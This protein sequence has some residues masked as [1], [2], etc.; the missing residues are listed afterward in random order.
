MK[1]SALIAALNEGPRIGGVVTGIR[2]HVADVLVV[3]DGSTDDTS[4][5]AQA[6]GASVIRHDVNR[7]KGQAIRT[8]LARVARR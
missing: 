5:A 4:A 2:R 1:V 3:D 8:G 6:A 7:G